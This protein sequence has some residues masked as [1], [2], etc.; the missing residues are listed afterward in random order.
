[1]SRA[2]QTQTKTASEVRN[3]AVDYVGKLDSGELL[4]GTPT[5]ATLLYGTTETTTAITVSN[6]TVSSTGLTIN[7]TTVAT[8][9]AVQCRVSAGTAGIKYDLKITCTSN[10]T[11]AQT[12]VDRCGLNVVAD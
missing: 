12:F 5:I 1:M 8:G 4:T 2:L 9:Q 11:P 6:I 10:S 3:V 7:G